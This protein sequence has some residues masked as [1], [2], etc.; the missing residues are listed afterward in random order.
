[1]KT[2]R[3]PMK[4][5][6]KPMKTYGKPMKTYRKP[7]KTYSQTAFRYPVRCSVAD[8]DF[9]A[10]DAAKRGHRPPLGPPSSDRARRVVKLPGGTAGPL[11]GR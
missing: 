5:Y 7:M 10:A 1:M 11:R 8:E 2:Y 6:R 4:T 3:K 9:S